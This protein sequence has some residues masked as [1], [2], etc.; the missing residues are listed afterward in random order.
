MRRPLRCAFA[1]VLVAALSACEGII[2]NPNGTV[3]DEI[4]DAGDRKRPGDVRIGGSPSSVSDAGESLAIV[5]AAVNAIAD[6]SMGPLV[7]AA[8]AP[9]LLPCTTPTGR[10]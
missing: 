9:D 6:A 3:A 8:I 7:D 10:L 4:P 2:G 1:L 5:D